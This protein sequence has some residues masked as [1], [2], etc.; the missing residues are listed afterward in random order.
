MI[1]N[2][3]Y[4]IGS[5]L[6]IDSIVV[7]IVNFLSICVEDEVTEGLHVAVANTRFSLA[8]SILGTKGLFHGIAY[9]IFIHIQGFVICKH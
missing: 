1:E 4:Y 5:S 3:K 7:I 8:R 6:E 9:N 2:T